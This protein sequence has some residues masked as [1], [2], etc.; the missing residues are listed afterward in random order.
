MTFS[1]LIS[2][3]VC[4]IPVICAFTFSWGLDWGVTGIWLGF[5]LAN[6]I[7]LVMY[8]VLIFTTDWDE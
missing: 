8:V 6:A 2:Y 3:Y 7:L 5:G 1:T 4:G